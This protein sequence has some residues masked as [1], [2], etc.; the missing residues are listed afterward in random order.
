M[1][2]NVKCADV[3]CVSP[4]FFQE[5]APNGERVICTNV[6]HNHERHVATFNLAEMTVRLIRRDKKFAEY[7]NK[8]LA[9]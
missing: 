3:G 8:L 2:Q 9:G 5:T 7:F 6:R 4:G 1:N